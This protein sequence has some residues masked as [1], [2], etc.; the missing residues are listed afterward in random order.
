MDASKLLHVLNDLSETDESYIQELIQNLK[1]YI[2][3]NNS[4]EITNTIQE[5]KNEIKLSTIEKYNKS[6]FEILEKIGGRNYYGKWGEYTLDDILTINSYNVN[7]TIE[8]LQEYA[9]DRKDFTDRIERVLDDLNELGIKIHKPSGNN[10]EIGLLMPDSYTHKKIPF[11]TKDLN[12]WDKIFKTFKELNGETPDDSELNFVS[13]GSLQFFIDNSPEVAVCL[14]VAIERIVNIYKKITEIRVTRLKLKELG[15]N[16]TEQKS[17][18]KQ[19]KEILNNEIDKISLDIIKDFA[20]K[21]IEKGRINEL[22]IAVKGHVTY[23]AK[24]V[25]GGMTIEINSPEVNEPKTDGKAAS[26]ANKLK[27]DYDKILKQVELTQKSMDVL[28]TIGKT[29][30]DIVKYLGNGNAEDENENTETE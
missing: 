10:F 16:T 29:G 4:D 15:I 21:N 1:S 14:A 9:D 5:I 26:E 24:C 18:E 20:T 12:R 2:R 27:T 11:I 19:E 8:D 23:I 13:N 25:D 6:D 3:N 7:K 22:K 17:I 28:K 30:I